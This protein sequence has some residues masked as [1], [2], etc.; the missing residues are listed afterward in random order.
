MKT[1]YDTPLFCSFL[2]PHRLQFFFQGGDAA[3]GPCL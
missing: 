3:L 1:V 2:L